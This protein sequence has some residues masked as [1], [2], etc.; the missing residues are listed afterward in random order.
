MSIVRWGLL[1]T[2]RINRKVIPSIRMSKRSQLVAVASRDFKKAIQYAGEWDIPRAF[3]S[4]EE[5][6]SSDE[7]DAVY[8]SLP[9]GLHAEWSIRALQA[10]KVV[11]HS[12]VNELDATLVELREMWSD[13]SALPLDPSVLEVKT[14]PQRLYII[15]HP[16]GRDLEFSLQDNHLLAASDRL[17][18]YRTPSEGG[19]SGSPVFGPT[20]WKV[21]AL[22]H[23]GRKDM[24]QLTGSGTYE[25]NEGI[26]LGAILRATA[27][28]IQVR[29]MAG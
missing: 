18:H 19:S 9:N 24:P 20:D 29:R 12:P 14:P 5:M 15:G 21:V 10:G 7:V 27:A 4:Y 2:A 13:A 23:A 28:D 3:S 6:L 16:G 22:H 17:V 26:A 11:F 1:S 8:I 25:A